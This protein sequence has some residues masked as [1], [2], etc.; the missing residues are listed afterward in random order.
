MMRGGTAGR[1]GGNAGG[2]G[3]GSGGGSGGGRGGGISGG[4]VKGGGKNLVR[5]SISTGGSRFLSVDRERE[6]RENVLRRNSVASVVTEHSETGRENEDK[7]EMES[8]QGMEK[9]KSY[10]LL[11]NRRFSQEYNRPGG[12]DCER[13]KPAGPAGCTLLLP[14][15]PALPL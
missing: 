6:L 1:G 13:R 10:S 2:R 9:Y 7:E 14:P 3:G 4:K 12:S 11:K 8:E 15:S 5:N